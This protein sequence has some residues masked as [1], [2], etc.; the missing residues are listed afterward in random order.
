MFDPRMDLVRPVDQIL[1]KPPSLTTS[2]PT[3]KEI[4]TT[5]L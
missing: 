1:A 4:T 3:A 2:Q 5:F